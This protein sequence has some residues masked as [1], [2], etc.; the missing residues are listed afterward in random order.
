MLINKTVAAVVMLAA[1][2]PLSAQAKWQDTHQKHD[3]A[4]LVAQ[5]TATPQ[6]VRA[7]GGALTLRTVNPAPQGDL[8]AANTQKP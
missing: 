6:P 4:I 5:G 7:G 2:A 8:Q 3:T 1:L